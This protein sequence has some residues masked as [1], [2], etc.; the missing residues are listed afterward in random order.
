MKT[1]EVVHAMPKT[2]DLVNWLGLVAVSEQS[3]I[4]V[5]E[6]RQYWILWSENRLRQQH[7]E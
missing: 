3:W 1:C 4:H 5:D 7:L 2:S 6:G